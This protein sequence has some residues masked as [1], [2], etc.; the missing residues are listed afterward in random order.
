M[1][2]IVTLSLISSILLSGM[3]FIDAKA[4]DRSSYYTSSNTKGKFDSRQTRASKR[5]QAKELE[6]QNLENQQEFAAAAR[7]DYDNGYTYSRI[8]KP[9]KNNYHSSNRSTKPS[10]LRNNYYQG[11]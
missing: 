5:R 10:K 8:I 11:N 7:I 9:L 1:R 3:I 6:A 4:Y 2:K